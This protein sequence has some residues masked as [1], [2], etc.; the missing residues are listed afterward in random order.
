MCGFY[1]LIPKTLASQWLRHGPWMPHLALYKAALPTLQQMWISQ[2]RVFRR[3]FIFAVQLVNCE[4][5]KVT[6]FRRCVDQSLT[7]TMLQAVS[8]F[9]EANKWLSDVL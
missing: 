7:S 4:D 6:N 3:E 2:K 5:K 1:C 9:P 8:G